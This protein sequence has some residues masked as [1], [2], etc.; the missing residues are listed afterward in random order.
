[1]LGKI[2]LFVPSLAGGGAER[3]MATLAS[4]FARRGYATQ[5]VLAKPEVEYASELDPS[6]EV[7]QLRTHRGIRT[8]L[9]LARHLRRER[10]DVLF[11]TIAEANIA[12]I[13]AR[14]IAR[15]P[16]RTVI[17]EASTPSIALFRSPSPK[18]RLAGRLLRWAYQRADAVI[19]VSQGVLHDLIE[20][21]QLPAYKVALIHN[22]VPIHRIR[23]LACEPV[24]HSWLLP[25][26]PPTILSVGN[27]KR[28]KDYP[29]L[30][31]AFAIV[32]RQIDARLLILGDGIERELLTHLIRELDLCAFVDMP[33]FDPNPFRYMRRARLFVLSSVYEGFPNVLVQALVCGCPVVSTDCTS[34][35]RD[36]TDQGRYGLLVPVGDVKRLAAAIV[37]ALQHPPAIPPESWLAQFDEERVT[38]QILRLLLPTSGS[39]S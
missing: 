9:P 30:L 32:R 29:T 1:M 4:N 36:I 33:G 39:A 37:E 22:P 2:C 7:V 20:I 26:S 6:I 17:R 13:V 28:A 19:A 11:S 23:A 31:R 16:V 27:L 8:V 35:P 14:Q 34:G 21:I 18:K 38:E 10:P 5:L 3:V 24:N 15:V 25:D 12:A